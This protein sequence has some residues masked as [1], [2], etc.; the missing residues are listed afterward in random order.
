MA[1]YKF[2][3]PKMGESVIEAT[4]LQWHKQVGDKINEHDV[5]VEVATDKVDS[6]VPSPVSGVLKQILH[7]KDAVVPV[8]NVLAIIETEGDEIQVTASNKEADNVVVVETK[9]EIK[10]PEVKE[11]L[12]LKPLKIP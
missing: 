6:E 9:N 4:V 2:L 11:L 7:D 3:L 1:A 12:K 10:P 8:G 5:L